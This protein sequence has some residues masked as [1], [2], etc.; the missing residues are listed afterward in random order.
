M[1]QRLIPVLVFFVVLMLGSAVLVYR[2]WR[3][4]VLEERLYGKP[5]PL[6]LGVP[7]GSYYGGGAAALEPASRF[8]N[9]VEQ[10]G[11]A[12]SAGKPEAGLR[13]WLAQAGYYHDSAPTI[14]VGAQLVLGLLALMI[15]GAAAF[16]FEMALVFRA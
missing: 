3:R 15:G 5:Q 10:I 14:Y 1:A 8:V 12:V 7:G 11:R 16:S 9:T 2:G 4:R 13:E 6:P